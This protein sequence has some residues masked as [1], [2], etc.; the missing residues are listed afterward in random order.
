MAIKDEQG[1]NAVEL[2]VELSRKVRDPNVELPADLRYEA[3]RYVDIA[4]GSDIDLPG[5]IREPSIE[6]PAGFRYGVTRYA[7]IILKQA[8]PQKFTDVVTNLE[9]FYIDYEADIKA[10]GGSRA[11]H[12]A[13]HD[14]G[15]T[16][17]GWAKHNV[18]IEK[19]V[20]GEP[21]FKVRNHEIDVFTMGDDGKYPGI[22]DEM[23]WNNK[24]P[25]FH[26]DLNNFQA[27]HR[28]GVIAVGVIITRGPRLQE[29][30]EYLASRGEYPKTKYGKATT[31]W[32]KLT[33]MIDMGGGGECP[34]LCIGI[35]PEKVNGL[36][37]GLLE[38]FRYSD[39]SQV[40]LG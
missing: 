31:H 37:I 24:D 13:R 36:P 6:L 33:P 26:R 30:L 23:E 15:L 32:N 25:F 1:D 11:R 4:A 27:L 18:T 39:G 16:D 40:R 19:R 21:V 20:D 22:A 38:D 9:E 34:L 8:F 3:T 14:Q 35:E 12:T 28:E 10:L 5:M 7:D 29:L 17:R 2:D